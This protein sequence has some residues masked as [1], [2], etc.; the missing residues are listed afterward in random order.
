MEFPP[1][2]SSIFPA[3]W[4]HL[5][6]SNRCLLL[7]LRLPTAA[8]SAI[9]HVVQGTQAHTHTTEE[10]YNPSIW[11]SFSFFRHCFCGG[12][13]PSFLSLD[14]HLG[15]GKERRR[16]R[17]RRRRRPYKKHATSL[18]LL[19]YF[20][21]SPLLRD[22]A[23]QPQSGRK[24]EE[25]EEE[26]GN[27][28]IH[29]GVECMAASCFGTMTMYWG[30]S[31]GKTDRDHFGEGGGGGGGGGKLPPPL[32]LQSLLRSAYVSTL[33]PLLLLHPFLPSFSSLGSFVC[34]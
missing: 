26:E 34:P 9:C 5:A 24:D 15:G 22:I 19:T 18:P 21:P 20:S 1:P 27:G 33:P 30:G 6:A 11:C 28:P 16:R 31:A 10:S 17:K 12:V 3:V 13:P 4:H 29:R 2:S 7:R 25:E 8:Q 32:L 14:R 23:R